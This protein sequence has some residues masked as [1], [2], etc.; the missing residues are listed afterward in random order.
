MTQETSFGPRF[1]LRT[2]GAPH[3]L[4]HSGPLKLRSKDLL[5][6]AYLRLEPGVHR[7]TTLAALLWAEHSEQGARHSLTQAVGRLRKVLGMAAIVTTRETVAWAGRLECDAAQLQEAE[8]RNEPG[9]LEFYTGEFLAGLSLGEGAH[10]F[11]SWASARRTEYM[12]LAAELLDR[13]GAAAEERGDW[14]A[15]LR[16]AQRQIE[17]DEYGES[18]HR[19]V[20]RALQALGERNRALQHY[21]QYKERVR[22]DMGLEP[23]AETTALYEAIRTAGAPTPLDTETP[24]PAAVDSGAPAELVPAAPDAEA[25]AAPEPQASHAARPLLLMTGA[26]A[27]VL[28]IALLATRGGRL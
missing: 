18:G 13:W 16:F 24:P 6:L 10:G 2:F 25:G 23:Q 3:L 22:R 12:D 21:L 27:A 20:M 28:V 1:Y 11:E 14:P 8:R 17:I 9:L 7:R 19:R 4:A 5:L 26:V 15:A